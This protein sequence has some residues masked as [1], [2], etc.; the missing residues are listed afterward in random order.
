MDASGML[1]AVEKSFWV[2]SHSIYT[3]FLSVE[4]HV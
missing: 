3:Y 2:G 4:E 1:R